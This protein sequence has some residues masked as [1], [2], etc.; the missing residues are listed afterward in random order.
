MGSLNSTTG[1][2]SL[3]EPDVETVKK[4]VI[5]MLANIN[6]KAASSNP[7]E[8]VDTIDAGD[9]IEI[10]DTINWQCDLSRKMTGSEASNDD[11]ILEVYDIS[12]AIKA[13]TFSEL[14]AIFNANIE[15]EPT[16]SLADMSDVFCNIARKYEID[17]ASLFWMSMVQSI[18]TDIAKN[19]VDSPIHDKGNY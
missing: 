4:E 15:T 6:P 19:T 2:D 11:I 16:F 12:E 9:A 18:D 14:S 10:N 1:L 13:Q 3:L 5:A 7:K 8:N 17:P